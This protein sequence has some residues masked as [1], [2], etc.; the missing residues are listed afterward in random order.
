MMGRSFG[1]TLPTNA[2]V[3]GVGSAPETLLCR[4]KFAPAVW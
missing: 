1:F 3:A 2:G 4:K